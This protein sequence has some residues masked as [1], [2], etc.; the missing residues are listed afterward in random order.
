MS[1]RIV[2]N[3]VVGRMPD[4]TEAVFGSEQEYEDA[5]YDRMFEMNNS[6]M[7]EMPEAF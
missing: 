5:F 4:N 3:K 6:F 7:A 2:N 1:F